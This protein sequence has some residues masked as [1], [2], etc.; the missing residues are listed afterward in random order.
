[1][2]LP[3]PIKGVLI[4]LAGVLHVGE[5]A[6][7][8]AVEALARLRATGLPLRFLTNTTRSPRSQILALMQR[9]GLDVRPEE[10]LTA[11]LATLKYVQ[12]RGL[13]PHYLIHPA[14]IEDMGESDPDPNVVVLGDAGDDFTYARMNA[15]FRLLMQGL[16]LVV[17]A[18]NKYFRE[19]DGLSLDMGAYVVGLEYS[20]GVT[21]QVIGKPARAF[22]EMALLD[23]GVLAQDAV[24]IGDDVL[25]DVGAAQL[26]GVAGILVRTGK[27]RKGD[28]QLPHVQPALVADD[29][30]AVVDVLLSRMH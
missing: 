13:R 6:V 12:R 26:A 4:D 5:A 11:A 14:I 9:V 27:F 19:A 17:M 2:R 16:P 23:M 8:G 24:M 30:S 18:R 15:A 7:P 21:A 3:E 10:V 22:F 28:D 1:M 29:F 25:D 20:A